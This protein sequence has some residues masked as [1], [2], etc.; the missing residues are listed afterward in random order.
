M[1][2]L[3]LNPKQLDPKKIAKVAIKMFFNISQ[4]W[5]LTSAQMHILLG[6]PSNSLFDKL[7][8]NEVSNL[9]QET[10]DRISFISGIYIAVHTIFE[11][12]NQANS[13]IT[14]QSTDFN[15]KSALEVML[16][17]SMAD[18]AFIRKYLD[19]RS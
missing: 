3:K 19:A 2:G 8:R 14:R 18:L 13:W 7:K 11:D 16:G 6:Q 9:P 1:P 5:A 10:L 17:G 4:Q 12:A 15:D